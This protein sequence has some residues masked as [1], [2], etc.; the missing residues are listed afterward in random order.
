ML[1]GVPC[2]DVPS[3]ASKRR[4][5]APGDHPKTL[6]DTL[7]NA[8]QHGDPTE[9]IKLVFQGFL[10]ILLATPG[11]SKATG[12]TIPKVAL[13]CRDAAVK[14]IVTYITQATEASDASPSVVAG[15]WAPCR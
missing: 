13:L 2:A 3:A 8:V 6:S 1:F 5:P 15:I 4:V 12:T 14:P 7:I 9:T 10:P 11:K